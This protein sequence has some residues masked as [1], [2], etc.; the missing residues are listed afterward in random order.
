VRRG[1][2]C[3]GARRAI[4]QRDLNEQRTTSRIGMK[5]TRRMLTYVG[6]KASCRHTTIGQQNQG[7]SLSL[8]IRQGT[9][10]VYTEF[11]PPKGIRRGRAAESP[12]GPYQR[13]I[14]KYIIVRPY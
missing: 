5:T 14:S 1:C 2:R 12:K 3:A 10:G 8:G 7:S 11:S 6:N 9:S 13:K 4:R